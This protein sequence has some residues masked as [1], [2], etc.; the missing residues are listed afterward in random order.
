MTT[1]ATCVRCHHPH[2]II[3]C[4]E[5]AINADHRAVRAAVALCQRCRYKANIDNRSAEQRTTRR[6]SLAIVML[7]QEL[8]ELPTVDE[9]AF[10][11]PVCR[12]SLVSLMHY[13]ECEKRS[14]PL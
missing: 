4:S 1:R 10:T 13:R 7:L 14:W 5:V 2:P 12:R 6:G 11:C 8:W 9:P 3:A